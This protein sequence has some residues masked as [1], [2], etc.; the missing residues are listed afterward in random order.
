MALEAAGPCYAVFAQGRVRYL[1]R[2]SG[3]SPRPFVRLRVHKCQPHIVSMAPDDCEFVPLYDD[4]AET[5]REA[6]VESS[7]SASRDRQRSGRGAT[8]GGTNGK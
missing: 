8:Q 4:Y 1:R 3:A 6:G 7:G 2:G 5:C